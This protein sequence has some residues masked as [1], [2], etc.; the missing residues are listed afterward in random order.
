MNGQR[1]NESVS[2]EKMNSV[3]ITLLRDVFIM[4]AL[5]GVVM[6]RNVQ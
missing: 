5:C 2:S 3:T 1:L 4:Q 6:T